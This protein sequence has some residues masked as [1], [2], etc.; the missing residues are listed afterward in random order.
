[1]DWSEG[2]YEKFK[3]WAVSHF[4]LKEGESDDEADV[5]ANFMKAKNI[6]FRKDRHGV[7]VLPHI[8][9]YRKAK[10]RQRVVRGYLGTVYSAFFSPIISMSFV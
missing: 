3:E 5:P 10:E 8:S 2:T 1:M 9:D 4:G 6:K 7:Y